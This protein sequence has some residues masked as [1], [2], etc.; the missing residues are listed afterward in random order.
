MPPRHATCKNVRGAGAAPLSSAPSSD[1]TARPITRRRY[2][3]LSHTQGSPMK[4]CLIPFPFALLLVSACQDPVATT[5]RIP[6]STKP[7]VALAASDSDS[8]IIVLSRD[9]PD[10][11]QRASDVAAAHNGRLSHVYRAALRRFSGPFSAAAI[12][13]IRGRRDVVPVEHDAPM[14]VVTT[15]TN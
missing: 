9:V 1:E 11:G 2:N 5:P 13:A 12:A 3:P 4:R 6:T 14:S 15:Q 10:V 7:A 8:Y